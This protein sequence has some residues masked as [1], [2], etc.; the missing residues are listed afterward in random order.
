VYSS[1]G[2]LSSTLRGDIG[3]YADI[4]A[5]RDRIPLMLRRIVLGNVATQIGGTLAA[6]ALTALILVLNARYLG[7]DRYGLYAASFALATLT[8]SLFGLGFDIWLLR[9][10]ARQRQR[11][12]QFVRAGVG[13]KV[14][15]G[16]PWLIILVVLAPAIKPSVFSAEMVLVSAV[17]V[18]LESVILTILSA[19]KAKLQNGIVVRILL[20]QRVLLLLMTLVAMLTNVQSVLS[21]ALIRM[22]CTG[23]LLVFVLRAFGSPLTPD[24]REMKR[25]GPELIPYALADLLSTVYMQ[26]DVTILAVFTNSGTVGIYALAVGVLNALFQIPSAAYQVLLPTL[27]SL[28]SNESVDESYRFRQTMRLTLLGMPA[29]GAGLWLAGGLALSPLIPQFFGLSYGLSG[30]LI[31]ILSPILYFKAI[32]YGLISVLLATGHQHG[33]LFAQ[34][35][36]ALGNIAANIIVAP[37][38]GALG[39]AW[40]YVASEIVLCAGYWTLW[41]YWRARDLPLFGKVVDLRYA[42]NGSGDRPYER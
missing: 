42:E 25:I 1:I 15:L 31:W 18:W 37:T 34:A 13:W 28:L 36:S 4:K 30:T 14:I 8:A 19:Y 21:F 26:A 6:Q 22:V 41:A 32:S 12:A 5:K 3:I 38:F 9:E 27:S 39:V 16:L 10:G 2:A 29:L 40:V 17:A 35:L 23:I 11:I 24:R 33:R 7:A 20:A